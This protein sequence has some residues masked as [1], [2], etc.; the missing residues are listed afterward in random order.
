MKKKTLARRLSDLST[1]HFT[2]PEWE[3]RKKQIQLKVEY[4]EEVKRQNSIRK[5]IL[6]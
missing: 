3:D 1:K 5:K 2:S 6:I 4:Q